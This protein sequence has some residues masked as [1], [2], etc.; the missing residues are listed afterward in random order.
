MRRLRAARLASVRVVAVF[1]LIVSG[2]CAPAPSASLIRVSHPASLVGTAWRLVSIDGHKPPSSP[3]VTIAFG[4]SD[5]SGDGPCNSFGGTYAYD[6]TIGAL[7]FGPLVSTKRACVDPVLNDAEAAY[8]GAL[9]GV[10]GASDDPNGRLVL[11]GA[12]PEL[13]FEVGPQLVPA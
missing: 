1:V 5:I 8:F 2:A 4:P 11:A 10:V 9:H 6:P 12:G 3:D 7:Q 13:V